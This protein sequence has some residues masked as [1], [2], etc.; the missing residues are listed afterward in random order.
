MVIAAAIIAATLA[1]GGKP[2]AIAIR[3]AVARFN[4]EAVFPLPEF[5]R[6]DVARLC[7]G[8]VVRKVEK[9]E[10]DDEPSRAVG[11]ALLEVPRANVW[12]S[13]QDPHFTAVDTATEK[14]LSRAGPDTSRATGRCTTGRGSR[15]PHS[16]D[17]GPMILD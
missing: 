11:L 1:H 3:G 15:Y 10:T 6:A 8:E 7:R 4:A 16:N 13:A 5:S 12:V 14:L 2:D 17:S 9:G